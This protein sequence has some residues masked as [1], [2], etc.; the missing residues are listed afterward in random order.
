MKRIVKGDNVKIIAGSL[1]GQTAEVERVDGDKVY[2]KGIRNIERH[3][4]ASA[5][6]MGGKRDIQL[7]I[8]ISNVK[9]LVDDQP[10][11]VGYLVKDDGSKVRVAKANGK[12]IAK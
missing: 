2:L 7:P 6:S 11:R 10:T 12:E 3:Y 4:R 5:Y 1:K 9:L 8:H